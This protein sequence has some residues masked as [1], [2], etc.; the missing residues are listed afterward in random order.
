MK[1]LTLIIAMT[2]GVMSCKKEQVTNVTNYEVTNYIS[3]VPF[4]SVKIHNDTLTCDGEGLTYEYIRINE[5][6]FK[7][8]RIFWKSQTNWTIW[9][10][11][12]IS[13]FS[14]N[15]LYINL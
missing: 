12:K 1:K 9:N 7:S 10:E 11:N 14:G 8:N 15:T 13:Y 2:L 4:Y 3:Q 6:Q 5:S